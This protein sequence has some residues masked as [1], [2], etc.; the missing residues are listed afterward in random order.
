VGNSGPGTEILP[1]QQYVPVA[2]PKPF[3]WPLTAALPAPWE[4]PPL[5]ER[6]RI[7]TPWWAYA[8]AVVLGVA[9]VS[10]V[11]ELLR[12]KRRR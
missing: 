10:V 7:E 9:G 3:Q 8:G 6:T 1:Y 12:N 11:V 5:P 4:P 2:A